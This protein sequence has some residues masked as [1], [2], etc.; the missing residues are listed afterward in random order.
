MAKR[1]KSL[2]ERVAEKWYPDEP[3]DGITPAEASSTVHRPAL[4]RLI[5]REAKKM[6]QEIID[7][8]KK[9]RE[10]RL[11]HLERIHKW[12][13]EHPHES[14][15]TTVLLTREA[16]ASCALDGETQCDPN[17]IPKPK[18]VRKRK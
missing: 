13:M 2:G 7:D 15:L 18:K 5:N 12:K 1:E 3:Y 6:Q 17:D 11:A 9:R 4:A 16:R 8:G 10:E 14:Y